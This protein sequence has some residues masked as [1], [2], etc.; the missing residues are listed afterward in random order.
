MVSGAPITTQNSRCGRA[1]G[2]RRRAPVENVHKARPHQGL[3]QRIPAN[4][5]AGPPHETPAK[6]VTVPVLGGLHHDY[7][8]AA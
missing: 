7:R 8:R 4:E 6:V 3:G 1:C 5:G 2:L